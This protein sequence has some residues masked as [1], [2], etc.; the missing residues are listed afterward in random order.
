[1]TRMEEFEALRQELTQT[2]PEL[3]ASVTRAKARAKKRFWKQRVF[4][5][6]IASAAALFAVFV[7]LVN[8]Y[9]PFAYACAG[10]PGLKNLAQAV[11]FNPS[12][13]EALENDYVQPVVAS[14]TIGEFTVTVDA[15]I[16]D[17]SQINVF[18]H[19]DSESYDEILS[20][21]ALRG[22][23]GE[24]LQ[25]AFLSTDTIMRSGE[26][27][28]STI[29][30]GPDA[31][32]PQSIRF[33][34]NIDCDAMDGGAYLPLEYEDFPAQEYTFTFDLSLN[35]Q[36]I[37]QAERYALNQWIELD[38][39]RILIESVE[40]YPTQIRIYLDDDEANTAW[41]QDLTCTFRDETGQ[42]T[43][44][45]HNGV[46]SLGSLEKDSPF[47][48]L[49]RESTFFWNSEHLTLLITGAKWIDKSQQYT[50][51]DLATG[52]ATTLLP[53][54]VYYATAYKEQDTLYVN[55]VAKD[56]GVSYGIATGAFHKIGE[57]DYTSS[58]STNGSYDRI[59][60]PEGYFASSLKA[61]NYPYDDFVIVEWSF[62]D[63][64]TFDSPIEIPIK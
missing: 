26:I 46:I 59:Y 6:P 36:T 43:D 61:E 64:S 13:R 51:F 62:T 19:V 42:E 29:D 49:H 63:K 9:V 54:S 22:E 55:S 35:D 53:S 44:A 5:V 45:F 1:M 48:S 3:E 60:I 34:I 12:L 4:G 31:A 52:N 39:Q 58:V 16:A 41:L 10:V 38:G 30:F 15:I 2:P 25:Y 27:T 56:E 7:V 11:T 17:A 40:I 50:T 8:V 14:R 18:Y 24:A 28:Y 33:S 57:E 37:Q 32:F 23:H 47:F 21:I 20:H